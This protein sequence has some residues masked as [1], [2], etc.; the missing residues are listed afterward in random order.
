MVGRKS[1]TIF[2]HFSLGCSAMLCSTLVL[3]LFSASLSAASPSSHDHT[4]SPRVHHIRRDPVHSL[5]LQVKAQDDMN[6]PDDLTVVAT[7]INKGTKTVKI[8]NDPNGPLSSWK[9]HTFNFVPIPSVGADGVKS[10]IGG[11]PPDVDSIRVKY[12]PVVAAALDDDSAYTILQPGENKTVVHDLSGMYNFHVSGGYT[13]KLASPAEYFNVIEE[14]G[15]ISRVPATLTTGEA[16]SGS[17]FNIPVGGLLTSKK[18]LFNTGIPSIDA[19]ALSLPN[20]RMIKRAGDPKFNNCSTEQQ[21]GIAQ[22]VEQANLYNEDAV[23][24]FNGTPGERYTTWFGALADNRTEVVRG[25]FANL[26]DKIDQFQF[27]CS[28]DKPDTFAYVYP[29]RFPTVYLCGAFWK[30]PT[31]GTDSKAGTIVHEGTHFVNIGGTDDYAYGQSGAKSLA[32]SDP[33]RAIMNADSHEYFKRLVERGHIYKGTHSGWYSISDECFY[34]ESQV[35]RIWDPKTGDSYVVSKETGQKV[36][37]S[38]EENYKFRLSHF[39]QHLIDWLRSNP[40]G[41][42]SNAKVFRVI[43]VLSTAIRP[44][45]YYRT[46]LDSLVNDENTT[47]DLSVSRPR[48]RLQWGIPVPG[49]HE[50]TIYVWFHAIYWPA[51]LLALD[52]QP[53]KTLLTHGHWTKDRQKMSKS[54]GN[55]A[56]PFLAMGFNQDGTP[57]QRAVVEPEK[58]RGELDIG[59]DGVRWYM[60]RAGGTFESDSDWSHNQAHKHYQR[61]LSGSLGNLVFR[62]IAPKFLARLPEIDKALKPTTIIQDIHPEDAQLNRLLDQ[63]PSLVEGYMDRLQIGRVPEAIVECLNEANRHIT[64]L[65]PWLPTSSTEVV[66]RA[67]K[68]SVETLRIIGIL[69]QPFIPAKAD[70]L[71][72]QLGVSYEDREWKDTGLWKGDPTVGRTSRATQQLFPR[73]RNTI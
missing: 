6:D 71:L 39:R 51:F 28:C 58:N 62:I 7:I 30:A 38:E 42:P 10:K 36:E 70:Q 63:L 8:L 37:W 72:T 15:S 18:G 47:S 45:P 56:D 32:S 59:V 40:Q 67:H 16:E 11:L 5:A 3:A 68:Y 9:T 14:D 26:T 17:I 2:C 33:D 31:N 55:V 64:Q 4:H 35:D 25:H 29:T 22:A 54:R 50:H 52:L 53:P 1:S 21:T 49:D 66:V 34:P 27:D 20:N 41:K 65:E 24:Y 60:L 23:G 48:S 19:L 44:E 57:K 43:Y 61:E 46:V 69:L 12:N 13:V 73:L